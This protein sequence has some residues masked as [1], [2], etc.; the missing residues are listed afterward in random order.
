MRKLAFILVGLMLALGAF[1]LAQHRH[2][3]GSHYSQGGRGGDYSYRTSSRQ[4]GGRGSQLSALEVFDL[5][6]NILNVVVGGVG[7][8]LAVVGLRMQRDSGSN[9]R[10]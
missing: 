7:I 6:V 1:S 5:V 8:Y 2:F 10:T 9:R 4:G 3:G